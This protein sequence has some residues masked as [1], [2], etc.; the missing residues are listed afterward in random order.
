LQLVDVAIG[1]FA[2]KRGQNK[3]A[4]AFKATVAVAS[5]TDV[6]ALKAALTSAFSTYAA[7]FTDEVAADLKLEVAEAP[8]P[9]APVGALTAQLTA[10]FVTALSTMPQ[11]I[12]QFDAQF[13][14]SAKS[15]SNLGFLGFDGSIMEK[16]VSFGYLPR[17]Y[18]IQLAR[19][20]NT[21]T[22]DLFSAVVVQGGLTVDG[23]NATKQTSIELQ[24]WFVPKTAKVVD[25]AKT[26]EEDGETMIK[27]DLVLGGGTEPGEFMRLFPQLKDNVIGLGPVIVQAHTVNE[28]MSIQSFKDSTTALQKILEAW[29]K[30]PQLLK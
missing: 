18:E 19:D 1:D 4:N 28:T 15:S 29:A 14:S 16:S 9:A 3:I 17:S 8:A 6:V 22:H 13:P 7:P 20:L 25:L 23:Q 24:P 10:S 30:D 21:K 11:G 27:G 5:G 12:Q 26:I 2:A